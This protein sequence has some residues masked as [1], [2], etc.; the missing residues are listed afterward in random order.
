MAPPRGV[1]PDARRWLVVLALL[2][3]PGTARASGPP[4]AAAVEALWARLSA[5]PDILAVQRA[6][7]RSASL[8]SLRGARLRSRWAHALPERLRVDVQ[9]T[10]DDGW[11]GTVYDDSGWTQRTGRDARTGWRVTAEW[12]LAR[13]VHD[14]DTIAIERTLA[15]ARRHRDAAVETATR[16]YFERR[17]LQLSYLLPQAISVAELTDLWLRI[18]EL[19]ARLDA[20]TGG[21]FR[22]A[23]VEWWREVAAP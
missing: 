12:D 17:R 13:I 9:H 16:L 4:G 10:D 1:G 6:A 2:A 11:H 14:P 20:T 22:R 23:R 21:L 3:I 8:R 15:E 18:A 7:A 19:T 5:E